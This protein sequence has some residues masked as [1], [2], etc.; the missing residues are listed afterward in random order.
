M[1]WWVVGEQFP[2]LVFCCIHFNEQALDA[3]RVVIH[4]GKGCHRSD[5][6]YRYRNRTFCRCYKSKHNYAYI[7]TL[8]ECS[9]VVD[10]VCV[11]LLVC[12]K[13]YSIW[14]RLF[15]HFISSKINGEIITTNN[16]DSD[17]DRPYVNYMSYE[18]FISF[19]TTDDGRKCL[20]ASSHVIMVCDRYLIRIE[21]Y[22]DFPF[23]ELDDII[24]SNFRMTFISWT[25][26]LT[27]TRR[28]QSGSCSMPNK[29]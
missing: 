13:M 17:P 7:P 1:A 25:G 4:D 22:Q 28:W 8:Q 23:I 2:L 18:T 15:I 21:I 5:R 10:Q 19:V 12:H 26:R 6:E 3:I 24:L 29:R 9:I 14:N 16:R 27:F 11:P 20:A